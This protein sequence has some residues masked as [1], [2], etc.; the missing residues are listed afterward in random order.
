MRQPFSAVEPG[1]W[2]RN[3][4]KVGGEVRPC[5]SA[6]EIGPVCSVNYVTGQIFMVTHQPSPGGEVNARRR[7]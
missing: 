2:S 7:M 1:G 4:W 5:I 6:W 3:F